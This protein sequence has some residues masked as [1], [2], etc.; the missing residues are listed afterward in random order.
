MEGLDYFFRSQRTRRTILTIEEVRSFATVYSRQF[1][2]L[3]KASNI[4][5]TGTE[6]VLLPL[7]I[8]GCNPTLSTFFTQ[9]ANCDVEQYKGIGIRFLAL[10]RTGCEVLVNFLKE[11]K[12][13]DD[14]VRERALRKLLTFLGKD[15]G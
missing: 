15:L 14:P 13:P 10:F 9:G 3:Q 11:K 4:L 8:I 2:I 1:S 6:H 7:K 12:I 5:M